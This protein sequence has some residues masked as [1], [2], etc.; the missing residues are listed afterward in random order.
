MGQEGTESQNGLGL[1]C[2]PRQDRPVNLVRLGH[3]GWETLWMGDRMYHLPVME[4][5]HDYVSNPGR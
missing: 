2:P 1:F 3:F 5:T 4:V